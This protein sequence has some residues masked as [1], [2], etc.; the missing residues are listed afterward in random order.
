MLQ[1]FSEGSTA[2]LVYR[3]GPRRGR[4]QCNILCPFVLVGPEFLAFD[5]IMTM[6]WRSPF[7]LLLAKSVGPNN[8]W[9]RQFKIVDVGATSVNFQMETDLDLII[10]ITERVISDQEGDISSTTLRE[11]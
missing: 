2:L 4:G 6:S 3:L 9:L 7:S 10:S 11:Q 5:W 8:F 1:H